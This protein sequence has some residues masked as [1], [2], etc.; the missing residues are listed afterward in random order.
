MTSYNTLKKIIP[1]DQALANKALS[2]SLLQVKGIF[3]T[4]LPEL[5]RVVS[6]LESNKDLDLINALE[7]PV[8]TAVIDYWTNSIGGNGTGPGNTLTLNDLIGTAAGATHSTELPVMTNVL[9]SLNSIGALDT[10]TGNGGTATSLT[11]GV[12]TVMEYCL[13]GA[14]NVYDPPGNVYG[15]LVS[16]DIPVGLPAAG[17]YTDF[18]DAFGNGLIP[19]ANSAI[20]LIASTYPTEVQQSNDSGN[21]MVD[22]LTINMVNCDSAG[23]DFAAIVNDLGN[24]NLQSNSS[25]TIM[26]LASQLHEIGTDISEGGAAQFFQ[27]TANTSTLTGQAVISSMREGR[28]IAVLNAIGIQTSSQL[29]GTNPN[30]QIANNLDIGQYTVAEAQANIKI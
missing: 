2:R 9:V 20:A 12:Y 8:P 15:N 10:L 24:A 5:S 11:N 16:I 14:Y 3:N 29:V 30:P 22:Q 25:S 19:A 18:D 27:A 17:S 4:T 26:A 23:L 13:A 7:T 21:A 6:V 1:P 28:N